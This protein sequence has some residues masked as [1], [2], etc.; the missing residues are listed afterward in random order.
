MALTVVLQEQ[1]ARKTSEIASHASLII[2]CGWVSAYLRLKCVQ[3]N[4]GPK[5]SPSIS[6]QDKAIIATKVADFVAQRGH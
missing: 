4:E 6:P 3:G 5:L 1:N 2:S